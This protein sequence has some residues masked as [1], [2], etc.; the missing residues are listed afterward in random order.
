MSKRKRDHVLTVDLTG[1]TVEREQVPERWLRQYLGGKGLGARYLYDRLDPETDPRDPDNLLAYMLGPLSG[2]LP[3]ESRYAVVTKSPLTGAFLDSYSGGGF[4]DRLAGALGDCLGLLVTG[5]ADT[6]VRIEIENGRCQI[7]PADHWGAD[8]VETASAFPDAGVACIGPAGEQGVA[9]ATIASDGGD[10]HAGRGGAG[11]VMGTKRLKAIVAR[12]DPPEPTPELRTLREQYEQLYAEHDTGQWQAAGGTFETVDFAN[13]IG[14]LATEGWQ[15]T[16]FDSVESIGIEAASDAAVDRESGA[17]PGDFRF[18]ADDG[19]V[20]LRGAAPMTL[21]AG[22]GIDRVEDVARLAETCDR[23]GIDVIDAGNAVAWTI[24]A[25]EADL[26]EYP[27]EF[28]DADGANALI[29]AIASRGTADCGDDESDADP[30]TPGLLAALAHGVD[31]AS[32]RFGGAEFIPTVKSMAFPSYD[33][34]G[35]PGMALAYATSD[36][37]ACHRRARPVETETAFG[38]DWSVQD[39]VRIVVGEQTVRSTLWSLIIDDFVGETMWEDLGQEWLASIDRPYTTRE[40]T[41]V[42]RRIWTLT[43]LFNAREG[44]DRTTDTVPN[45]LLSP[46][47][48]V[49]GGVDAE[50]FERTLD[51]YYRACGWGPN[52]LPTHATVE[53]LDLLDAVDDGTPLDEPW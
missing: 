20:V 51:A 32:D 41:R 39:R 52:G 7:T 19:Q 15:Q 44:F 35:A 2:F 4:V 33:P 18:E 38:T 9:Y 34:R 1:E 25:K 47:S 27:I 50:A 3:G 12:G 13:E 43:R 14:A 42:G 29:E 46:G 26:V 23:L 48:G 37:G 10:H 17:V 24:R 5:R 28:G 16:R 6:P 22:L 8:T 31:T 40:L 11:T 21:G 53:R 49:N 36:R 30:E 45:E